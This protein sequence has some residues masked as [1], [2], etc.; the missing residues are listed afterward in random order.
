[1]KKILVLFFLF[2]EIFVVDVGATQIFINNRNSGCEAIILNNRVLVPVRGVFEKLGYKVL[3]DKN[4]ETALLVNSE[5]RI[6]IRNGSE[7]IYIN[8]KAIKPDVA[9][10]I[11]DGKMFI[12]LRAISEAVK[13]NIEW[14]E[15]TK[16]VIITTS[17][18]IVTLNEISRINTLENIMNTYNSVNIVNSYKNLVSEDIA[19][20]YEIS[21]GKD[22]SGNYIYIYSDS[23]GLKRLMCYQGEFT[24]SPDG[25]TFSAF[26]E[27]DEQ[28][29]NSI[30]NCYNF[31]DSSLII[32]NS[33]N[34]T[35]FSANKLKNHYKATVTIVQDTSTPTY[36]VW[37]DAWGIKDKKFDVCYEYKL[38]KDTLAVLDSTVFCS[39]SGGRFDVGSTKIKYGQSVSIPKEFE[40]II[41]EKPSVSA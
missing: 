17:E 13:A 41:S 39:L 38:D 26:F 7:Y 4:T 22:E 15:N 3:W 32:A 31:V 35:I 5:N 30:M 6:T 23:N 20:S 12:P 16:N 24:I 37:A 2:L 25:E 1:M 21:F 9:Q 10:I 29:N 19:Q 28:R 33:E 11:I 18:K 40:K 34:G 36:G 27:N 8:A 14:D